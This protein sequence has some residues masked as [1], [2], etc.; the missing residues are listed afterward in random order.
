MGIRKSLSQVLFNA[1]KA[2]QEDKSKERVKDLVTVSRVKLATAIMPKSSTHKHYWSCLPI[3]LAVTTALVSHGTE[4]IQ[5]S[6]TSNTVA[7]LRG[8]STSR[9]VLSVVAYPQ[10]SKN[11]LQ[12]WKSST[13]IATQLSSNQ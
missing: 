5:H 3:N 9:H 2:L 11:F 1:A 6:F 8:G 13:T 12:R 4:V 7:S 10:V